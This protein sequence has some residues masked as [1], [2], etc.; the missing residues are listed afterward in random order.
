MS[1]KKIRKPRQEPPIDVLEVSRLYRGTTEGDWRVGWFD[2]PGQVL[3]ETGPEDE[4]VWIAR[5]LTAADANFAV[6]AHRL[7][8]QAVMELAETRDRLRDIQRILTHSRGKLERVQEIS[9]EWNSHAPKYSMHV[10]LA[11][12]R[13]QEAIDGP[14]TRS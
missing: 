7:L 1:E 6:E 2:G 14:D 11:G 5:D 12:R 10:G 4:P 3:I 9:D 8:R 13:L